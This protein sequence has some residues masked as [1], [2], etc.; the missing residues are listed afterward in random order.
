[1]KANESLSPL[2]QNSKQKSNNKTNI[3]FD[4]IN[5]LYDISSL[6]N[7]TED[8]HL[9]LE[10]IIDKLMD[11][12]PAN[13]ASI[14]LIRI[15]SNLLEIEV[16]KGLPKA[17]TQHSM[18]LG[19]GITGRVALNGV[20][21]NCPD[22]S[23]EARYLSISKKVKSEMA[24][25]LK[26]QGVITGVINIDSYDR[27]AFSKADLK[28]LTLLAN[29]AGKVVSKIWLVKQLKTKAD[30]LQALIGL[31]Q[32]MITKLKLEEVLETIANEGRSILNGHLA[33]I[34]LFDENDKKLSLSILTGKK[35]RI[36]HRETLN[37]DESSLGYAFNKNKQVE[38]TDI[39]KTEESH[40][41]S[42]QNRAKLRSMICTPITFEDKVIGLFNIYTDKIRLFNN[43]EKLILETLASMGA[44]TIQNTLLYSKVFSTEEHL[45]KNEKLT[46]LGILSAEI[47]HEIRNPLTVIKLL[48]DAMGLSFGDDDP[49]TKDISIISEKLKQ[50]E[51]IVSRVLDFGK[52][53][54][55]IK[56]N[57][58]I[59]ELIEDV[60]QLVRLKLA[61]SNIELSYSLPSKELAINASKGQLQQVFLNL[62]INATEAMPHGGKIRFEIDEKDD[63]C[64]IQISDT[65][66]GIPKNIHTQIFDSFLSAKEHGTGLGLSIVKRILRSHNGDIELINSS[67]KGTVFSVKL[68]LEKEAY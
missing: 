62:I 15:E 47:A 55:E 21:I 23:T 11:L 26:E 59:N 32:K 29:E 2:T 19:I 44:V 57:V 68:P 42:L 12:L 37:L 40:F 39:L 50:L 53:D 7:T 54:K 41:I 51:S 9:A 67:K 38:V 30:Q 46:T 17:V 66:T 24:V 10:F 31:S 5:A 6:I 58:F 63:N 8:P 34:Y 4:V 43:D 49:R 52:N 65:G 48:F 16:S 22:V 35:G 20:A 1:M 28:V 36:N 56:S 61:Q 3:E 27:N 45:R 25:P 14:S 13:S 64:I 60:G 33:A 18:P